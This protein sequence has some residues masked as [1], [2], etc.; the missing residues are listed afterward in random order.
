[1]ADQKFVPF[2]RPSIGAEEIQSVEQV[3]SSGWLTTGPVSITFQQQ[4]AS[5]VGC[6][7]AL[8]VNSATAAL[9]LALDCLNLQPYD[10]VLVP[11]Y[12]FTATAAVVIHAGARPVLCDSIESGFNISV[13]ELE[14]RVTTRTK[15]IIP[16][17]IAGHPCDLDDIRA[18]AAKHGIP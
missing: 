17:H 13:E 14:R 3:L 1:M 5:F 7:Y 2:H 12:T 4:F 8:A 11:T 18:L 16:V 6:K 15:A 9:R 10:E